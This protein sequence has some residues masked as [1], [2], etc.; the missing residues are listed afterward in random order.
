MYFA[1]DKAPGPNRQN[2]WQWPP[3]GNTLERTPGLTGKDLAE[4]VE[5]LE[6]KLAWFGLK[7]VRVGPFVRV[8]D[9]TVS[10]A[11]IDQGGLSYSIE[12]EGRS[13]RIKP[14]SGDALRLLMTSLPR[15]RSKPT[16]LC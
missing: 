6:R 11:L 12:L 10:I 7:S 9:D 14:S 8:K 3:S 13:R 5:L 1:S 16:N 15:N 4:I 2:C